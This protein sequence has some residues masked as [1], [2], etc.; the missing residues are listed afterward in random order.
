[1]GA[2]QHLLSKAIVGGETCKVLGTNEASGPRPFLSEC[3]Q[4]GMLEKTR[5]VSFIKLFLKG[6]VAS[7]SLDHNSL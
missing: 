3:S 4:T 5:D 6:K 2:W 1:M 7:T